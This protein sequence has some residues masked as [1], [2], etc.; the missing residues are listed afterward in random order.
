M[1]DLVIDRDAATTDIQVLEQALAGRFSYLEVSNVDLR[2]QCDALRSVLPSQVETPWFGMQLQKLVAGF[3]D[4]HIGVNARPHP[5]GFFPFLTGLV[6]DRIAAFESDR[7]ALLDP[8]RPYL[9]SIDGVPIEKWLDAAAQFVPAGSPQ[10]KARNSLIWLRAAQLL[11]AELR[12]PQ[13]DT[14]VVEVT[15]NTGDDTRTMTFEIVERAP[16]FGKW[17]R[18]ETRL[19]EGNVGYLRI[20]AMSSEAAEE[21][22]EAMT[23]F[24]DTVGLVIDVRGNSGGNRDLLLALLPYLMDP[25]EGPR[26]VNIAAYRRS[27]GVPEDYLAN[28][29]L[30]PVDSKVWPTE[31][32]QILD[33]FMQGFEPEW[34]PAPVDFSEWH[35]MLVSPKTDRPITRYL[36]RPVA[37]LMDAASFSATD[38]LLSAL[39]GM[40]QVTLVGT[41]S[42]GGSARAQVVELPNSGLMVR[43]ATMASFQA[44][45]Q[46]FDGRG[47]Q[48]DLAVSST[49]ECYLVRGSDYVLDEA[50]KVLKGGGIS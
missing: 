50:L 8:D 41:P 29:Y 11:R 30:Y 48:P 16:Q 1:G 5:S 28:R 47:V 7:S 23:L 9:R 3:V 34:T 20:A 45:G 15:S 21:I 46:L 39:K 10:F 38:I 25:D 18:T 37:V 42:G 32:R 14:A 33:S 6:G 4:G 31:E 12:L 22:A 13:K 19:L 49:P 26:V 35:A 40:P 27:D 36:D 24:A 44:S 17:P 2:A 43:F